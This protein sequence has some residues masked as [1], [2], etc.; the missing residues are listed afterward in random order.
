MNPLTIILPLPALKCVWQGA[1]WVPM[2]SFWAMSPLWP[3]F[4]VGREVLPGRLQLESV[5]G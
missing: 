2:G 1:G 4:L 3:G 5:A